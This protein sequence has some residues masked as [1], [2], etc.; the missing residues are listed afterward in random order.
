M[1]KSILNLKEVQILEKQQQKQIHAGNWYGVDCSLQQNWQH[2]CCYGS[3][4][5]Q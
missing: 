4:A 3:L 5:C 1:L 2:P